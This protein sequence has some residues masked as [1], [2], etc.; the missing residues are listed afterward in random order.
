MSIM[1]AIATRWAAVPELV[2]LIPPAQLIRGEPILGWPLPGLA[3]TT[4]SR[5]KKVRTSQ[6]A[7]E[8]VNLSLIIEATSAATI[9]TIGDTILAELLPVP[10]GPRAL[11]EWTTYTMAISRD[12][13]SEHYVG[14]A[15]LAF[16]FW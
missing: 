7:G 14:Q 8:V 4:I 13:T 12:P 1:E 3:I 5:A 11:R 15:E 9:E 2:A 10:V 6:G 16:H